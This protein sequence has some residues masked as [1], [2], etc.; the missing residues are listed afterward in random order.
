MSRIDEPLGLTWV[1]KMKV[2]V[3]VFGT[4]SCEEENWQS[5]I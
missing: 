4:V 5:K 2:V 1:R 3:V